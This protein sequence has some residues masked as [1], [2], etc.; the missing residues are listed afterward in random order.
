MYPRR[1]H[2]SVHTVR[3]TFRERGKYRAK[4]RIMPGTKY[5]VRKTLRFLVPSIRKSV[6]VHTAETIVHAVRIT[7]SIAG[8]TEVFGRVFRG[9]H[10]A[11]SPNAKA[12]SNTRLRCTCSVGAS[13]SR[14]YSENTV[15]K[16]S[17]TVNDTVGRRHARKK[18]STAPITPNARI[19]GLAGIR[20]VL[21]S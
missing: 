5:P 20:G 19:A 16:M 18:T 3:E 11:A 8:V 7:I 9:I 17:H 10:P 12:V 6:P 15:L 21:L 14:M 13:G 4:Y 1:R 2:K